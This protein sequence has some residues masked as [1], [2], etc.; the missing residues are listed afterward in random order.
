[1]DYVLLSFFEVNRTRKTS[2]P[3]FQCFFSRL[4][5]VRNGGHFECNEN[6]KKSYLLPQQ[7]LQANNEASWLEHFHF[8]LACWKQ[9]LF[10][11]LATGPQLD[12]LETLIRGETTKLKGRGCYS[13][14]SGIKNA[15]LVILRLF[16]LKSSTVG[17][18]AVPFR[19]LNR[20]RQDRR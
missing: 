6:E 13:Y 19:V 9:H 5:R 7:R 20:K 3:I 8:L 15:V 14:L 4:V 12:S 2:V 1:M 17:T 10:C 18:F 16:G 11:K